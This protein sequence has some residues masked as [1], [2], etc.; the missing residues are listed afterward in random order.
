MQIDSL[1]TPPG[2]DVYYDPDFHVVLESHLLYFRERSDT[3]IETI[4]DLKP[5]KYNGSFFDIL[6]SLSIEKQYHW[7]I[8]RLNDLRSPFDY[9]SDM[10]VIL[11]PSFNEIE[12][13]KNTFITRKNNS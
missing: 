2:E 12:R 3:T 1:M 13:I 8:M 10:T 7:F 6:D 9:T 4:S 5:I 11:I